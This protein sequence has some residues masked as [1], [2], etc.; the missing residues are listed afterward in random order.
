MINCQA[1][2]WPR[3]EVK[4]WTV[5]P[6]PGDSPRGPLSGGL[7]RIQLFRKWISNIGK[8][9]FFLGITVRFSIE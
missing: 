6:F 1:E 5:T 7:L 3:Q 2:P 9:V 4:V 8:D